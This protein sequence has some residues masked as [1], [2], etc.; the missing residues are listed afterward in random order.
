MR[1]TRR[2]ALASIGAVG[3][4]GSAVFGSGAFTQTEVD[5]D[6]N[7]GIANDENAL[8]SFE[9]KGIND[10]AG[11]EA[12]SED[13]DDL[14][15]FDFDEGFDH[16]DGI[17]SA[18]DTEFRSAFTIENNSSESVWVW[19]PTMDIDSQDENGDIDVEPSSLYDSGDRSVELVVD[20][21]ESD[22]N[23]DVGGNVNH[24]T[25]SRADDHAEDPI[26]LT[27]PNGL[28]KNPSEEGDAPDEPS[29]SGADEQ[30]NSFGMTPGG[31]IELDAGGSVDVDIVFLIAN[32]VGE[33]E[34]F[35]IHDGT[36]WRFR[37]TR[38]QPSD[39]QDWTTNMDFAD[40]AWQE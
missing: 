39:E 27:F 37:A 5:R 26:D 38:S 35:T 23:D 1:F 11:T 10:T 16:A 21:D 34:S 25:R 9:P 13:E 4:G 12:V 20:A 18:A 24:G 7:L 17:N 29:G 28:H 8:L 33:G 22:V 14:I 2:K 31:A 30:S 6:Y 19:L 3:I 32:V 15:Q 36:N 40:F